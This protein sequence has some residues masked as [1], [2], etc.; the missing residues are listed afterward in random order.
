[1]QETWVR[2]L[3]REDPVATTTELVLRS[4]RAI[5]TEA[6]MPQSPC[7]TREAPA[8]RGPGTTLTS[9][10]LL[11]ATRESPHATTK[12]QHSQ[13]KQ[14]FLKTHNEATIIRPVWHW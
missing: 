9:K 14:K 7:V 3:I 5:T 4:C 11:S 1:M 2:A 6:R 10:P 13:N 12:I 8:P